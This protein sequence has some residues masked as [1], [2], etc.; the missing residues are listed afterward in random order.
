MPNA[1]NTLQLLKVEDV[2]TQN[3]VTI[4]ITGTVQDAADL[5]VATDVR[6]IPVV[7]K[8]TLVGMISD[9]D[10]RSYMLPRPERIS[11]ADRGTCPYG[12]Q[13]Q[14]GMLIEMAGTTASGTISLA[15]TPVPG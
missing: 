3:P 14:L 12:R 5:M 4:D 7:T 15:V 11:R 1:H 6:H 13:R 10:L 9:R 8:G 2:I